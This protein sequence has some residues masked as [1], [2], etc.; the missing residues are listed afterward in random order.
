MLLLLLLLSMT[1]RNNVAKQTNDLMKR[2]IKMNGNINNPVQDTH[3]H[4]HKHGVKIN[5]MQIICR[6][7][8]SIPCDVDRGNYG[9]MGISWKW[10]L[11]TIELNGNECENGWYSLY[12]HA[13]MNSLFSLFCC[14][15]W[16]HSSTILSWAKFSLPIISLFLRKQ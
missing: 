5:I 7:F 12:I 13:R 11:T 15:L 6:D 4:T 1:E 9:T 10:F 8:I 16:M 2:I 14:A 3:T